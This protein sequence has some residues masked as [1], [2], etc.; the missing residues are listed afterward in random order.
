VDFE[1]LAVSLKRYPD[2]KPSD[3]KPSY[4]KPSD[5][6]PSFSAN[7]SAA[8]GVATYGA[9]EQAAGKVSPH[10]NFTSA[11]KAASENKPL[12]AAVNRCATQ[13]QRQHEFFL[14]L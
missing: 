2:T 6:K 13:N 11:A 3:T 8:N 5:T 14:S 9:A 7:G 1:G 4:T 10:R 12:I